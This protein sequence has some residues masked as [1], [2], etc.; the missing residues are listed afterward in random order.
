MAKRKYAEI[1]Q[2][3]AQ[4]FAEKGFYGAT[5]QDI[6]DSLGMN[7]SSLY[8]YVKGK[9]D[10]VKGLVEEVLQDILAEARS[11]VETGH[12]PLE[13]M[14]RIIEAHLRHFLAHR[15]AF[16]VFLHEDPKLL[17]RF[18]Q[19]DVQRVMRDYDDLLIGLVKEG[20]SQGV[21]RPD[22]NPKLCVL[23]IFGMCNYTSKWY[24]PQGSLSSAEVARVFAEIALKGIS[25]PS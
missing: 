10:L 3:A 9:E 22:L 7:K 16:A 25:G 13:K 8:Y 17:D 1:I 11:V 21:F 5:M 18:S 4:V 19:A 2:A 15:S 20:Q 14:Q 12:T 24:D 6:A 23:G